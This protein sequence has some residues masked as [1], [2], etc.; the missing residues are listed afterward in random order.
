[1]GLEGECP[2]GYDHG[3]VPLVPRDHLHHALSPPGGGVRW[4]G[5][6]YETFGDCLVVVMVSLLKT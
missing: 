2:F 5:F 4:N 1:M 3:T 6:P